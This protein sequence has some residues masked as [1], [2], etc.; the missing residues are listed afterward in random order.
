ML[1]CHWPSC[2]CFRAT[3]SARLSWRNK[4]PREGRA[5]GVSSFRRVSASARRGSRGRR[6][7]RRNTDLL[8]RV[9]LQGE[10]IESSFVILANAGT[11]PWE[12]DGSP[13]PRGRPERVESDGARA[14]QGCANVAERR[15]AL[16]R[17]SASVTEFFRG[18][19]TWRN[20]HIY[21]ERLFRARASRNSHCSGRVRRL[22]TAAGNLNEPR[23][24]LEGGSASPARRDVGRARRQFRAVL[25]ARDESRAVPVRRSTGERSSSASRC[26]NTPTR[27]GTA[28]CP[29]RDPAPSTAIA[30]TG[31]T[32]PSRATASI[33]TS[34]CSI[35]T[36]AIV[37]EL[38]VGSR[39]ASATRS[40]PKATISRSTSATARRS[41]RSAVVVDPGFDWGR[42]R[43]ARWCRGIARSSTRRTC[44]ATRC[45]IPPCPKQLRGTFAGLAVP[46]SRRTTSRQLGVTSVELLPVQAF[47]N[48]SHLLD[49]GLTNYWGYNTIGFFAPI[50]ATSPT[51]ARRAGIQGDGRALARRGHRGDS[52]RRLQPHAPKA[53]SAARRCASRASTTRPTTA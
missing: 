27:S 29:T 53:T 28:I 35:R 24:S 26:P 51:D 33:R 21:T 8:R 6:D 23:V 12:G 3:A 22:P 32:S 39:A 7:V 1:C 18:F 47:V 9:R 2:A 44:A 25:G 46:R 52:R 14:A 15:D 36:R 4:G 30:C 48:D 10:S 31:R 11:H 50:R 43:Q 5:R 20:A 49:K 19:P 42:E 45:A 37:G 38:R 41:C 13:P 16:E 40:A 17:P 34:C